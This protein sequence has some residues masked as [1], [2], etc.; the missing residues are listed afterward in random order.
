MKIGKL[1]IGLSMALIVGFV[2]AVALCFRALN[3]AQAVAA[4]EAEM[5]IVVDAGHGGVD[6]G[7]VGKTTGIKESD[8]NLAIAHFLCAELTDIGFE[9]VMTRKTEA[10]LYGAAT[11]GFKKRDMQQRKEIIAEA[12]PDLVLSIHQNFYPTKAARGGQ[13]F[14]RKENQ[15][16]KMLALAVQG[17]LND[18]YL[19]K[20]VKNRVAKTG[21][22][23]MLECCACPSVIVEC[24]F[25]SN[26]ADEE[27]L[28]SEGWQKRL[29]Q[30]IAA[31]VV[32][33]FANSVA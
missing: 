1:F 12:N 6:G 9:V 20:G 2:S 19:D 13:V 7:V 11:K 24:G 14:Y 16:S 22:Y 4:V 28:T 15:A 32:A 8:I 5:R 31:G 29:A 10:G 25:L 21:E 17:R 27:L 30:N 3:S 23:F 26:A 18:L 33:Y